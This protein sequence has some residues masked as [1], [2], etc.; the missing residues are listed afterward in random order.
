[1]GWSAWLP[2]QATRDPISISLPA[3]TVLLRLTHPYAYAID[4]PSGHAP[5][6]D[7]SIGHRFFL[8]QP[9]AMSTFPGADDGVK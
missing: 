8:R 4:L 5:A 7:R 9:R 2:V 3:I 6:L 1:M